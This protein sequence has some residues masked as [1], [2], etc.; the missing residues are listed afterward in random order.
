MGH[1]VPKDDLDNY[2]N[3]KAQGSHLGPR[4]SFDQEKIITHCQINSKRNWN[5]NRRIGN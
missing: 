4:V 2:Y 1:F 5:D 3:V